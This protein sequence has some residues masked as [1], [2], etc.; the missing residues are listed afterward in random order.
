MRVV[1]WQPHERIVWPQR[2]RHRVAL[3]KECELSGQIEGVVGILPY[4]GGS[5]NGAFSHNL[6][7]RT[8]YNHLGRATRV[9]G[10]NEEVR[11]SGVSCGWPR[12]V[13]PDRF[14]VVNTEVGVVVLVV[15]LGSFRAESVAT[16][17]HAFVALHSHRIPSYN[18]TNKE[19]RTIQGYAYDSRTP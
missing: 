16:I 19:H 13:T 6:Q 1:T 9:H 7:P 10:V 12:M 17:C 14:I 11:D 15:D 18:H 4:Q 2:H 5:C 8:P 3:L